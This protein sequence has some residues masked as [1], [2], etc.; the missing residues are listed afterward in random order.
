MLL[1]LIVGGIVLGALL[2]GDDEDPRVG[3]VPDAR[4]LAPSLNA[5][6]GA[7]GTPV[8]VRDVPDEQAARAQVADGELDVALVARGDGYDAITDQE[9]PP[10]LGAVL[11]GAVRQDALGGALQDQGVDPARLAA[12]TSASGWRSSRSCSCTSSSAP[13]AS[14]SRPGWSRRRRA[15]SSRSCCRR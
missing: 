3:L 1:V 14:P 10:D 2:G 7:V 9:V 5:V 6:A 11:D 13:P 4:S 12:A 15:A 8:S